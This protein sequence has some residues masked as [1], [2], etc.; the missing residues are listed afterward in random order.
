MECLKEN[1][2]LKDENIKL[3]KAEK[4]YIY[5]AGLVGRITYLRLKNQYKIEGFVVSNIKENEDKLYGIGVY[6]ISQI[7]DCPD[8]TIFIIGVSDKYQDE[9]IKSLIENGY[10]NWIYSC[11]E[12]LS[13]NYYIKNQEKLDINTET[14]DWYRV[15]TGKD[16]DI[17]HPVS[18]NEK[19][20]WLKIN[21]NTR[22]KTELSDKVSVRSY[23]EKKIGK[24][25]LVP[26]L[27]VWGAFE[28][29][30]FDVLPNKFVLKC[31]HASGT[32]FIVKNK[33]DIDYD[34]VKKQFD[35]WMEM[36]YAYA[37]GFEMQYD[38]IKR[39]IYAEQYIEQEDGDL[40]DYKLHC[41]SGKVKIIQVIFSRNHK[42]HFAYEA[43]FDPNWNRNNL[44]YNTYKQYEGEI[45]KPKKLDEMIEVAERLSSSFR[46]VRVDLYEVKGKVYFGEMTFTP[47][48]GIGKWSNTMDNEIVGGMINIE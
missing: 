48:S 4:I 37:S 6:E 36:N 38:K 3:M 32:N 44:M 30:P 17:E 19:I 8:K 10:N 14:L 9:V 23:V 42:T 12:P 40:C 7:K 21:D 22:I 16:I 35:D 31:N 11:I 47:A 25:Y 20:Q 13:Y 18:Y 43:F 39:K 26:I 46:Y 41:F 1:S 2:E 24:Q 34:T 28:D 15:C 29:I 45:E 33:D 27:G 5:G